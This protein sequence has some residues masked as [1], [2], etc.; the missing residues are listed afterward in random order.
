[1]NC[2]C[3]CELEPWPIEHPDFTQVWVCHKCGETFYRHSD[4]KDEH[5]HAG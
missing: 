3:G 2:I 5:K 4:L 1:M